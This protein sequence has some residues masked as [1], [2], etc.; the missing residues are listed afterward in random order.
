MPIE[1]REGSLFESGAQV[2]VNPVNA[3]G[4]M[5]KGVAVVFKGKYPKM[6]ESYQ[7]ACQQKQ[8]FAGDVHTYFGEQIIFNAVTK[9]HWRDP[10]K[11]IYVDSCLKR[12]SEIIEYSDIE[13]IAIPALGCGLGNLNWRDVQPLIESNLCESKATVIAF[14]PR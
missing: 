7:R 10:S 5:G 1:Y 12:I 13:S 4:V 6:F 14:L 2:L 3:M 11:L 9:Q 8:L